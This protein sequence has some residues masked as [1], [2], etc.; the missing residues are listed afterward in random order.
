MD[1][2]IEWTALYRRHNARWDADRC[3]YAYL[4]PTRNQL[5]YVGKAD[6]CTLLQRMRGDHKEQLFFDLSQRFRYRVHVGPRV[7]HGA[8]QILNGQRF[9]SA[10][11]HDLE[12]LLIKRFD[13][14][15]N[16]QRAR[17]WRPGLQLDCVGDWPFRR[18]RFRDNHSAW[19]PS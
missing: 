14:W 7:L 10:L 16:I 1:V 11:L 8:I 17:S 9:S 3:L 5:L 2:V 13:P 19:R 15:G 6:Y 4:H 12:T 18:S